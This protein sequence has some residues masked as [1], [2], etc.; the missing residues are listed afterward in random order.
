MN[1]QA[2]LAGLL[3]LAVLL[4]CVRLLA[5]QWRA[6]H[7]SRGWRLALLLI[8]QPLCAVLLY[9]TLLPPGV[10]GRAGTMVVLTAGA[11]ATAAARSAPGDVVIA[12][13]EAAA[14]AAA[15]P[16]GVERAPDLATAL[17]RHPGSRRLHVVG[18]GL[19]ARDRDAVRGRSLHFDASP[20]PAGLVRLEVPERIAPGAAFTIGGAVNGIARGTVELLD[21]AGQRVDAIALD[22]DGAFML[23][24]TVRAPGL[25]GF[26]LRIRDARRM[27]REEVE[28][29]LWVAADPAPRVLLLAGAANPELK[30]L[31][32]WIADAGM[33]AHALI[34]VG[35]G[36]QLGDAPLPLNAATFE[37]FDLLVLDERAWAALGE[38]QRVALIDAVRDGLGVLLRVTGPLSEASRRQLRGLG[39]IVSAGNDSA[40]ARL[41]ERA[42]DDDSLRARRG[43]GS[44]EAP[45]DADAGDAPVL[46]RRVLRIEAGDAASGLRDGA[47]AS[48]AEWRAEGRG[49]IG[50]WTLTDSYR[51]V[52]EGHGD[53]HGELWSDAFATLAR[54]QARQ[55][56]RIDRAARVQQRMR[57]CGISAGARVISADGTTTTLLPDPATGTPACAAYWPAEAGWHLLVQG[58]SSWPF[59]VRAGGEAPALRA[60]E[61]RE[62]TLRLAGERETATSA[63]GD[64]PGDRRGAS[65]PWFLAWLLASA[66]L[67]WFER[68]RLGRAAAAAAV[69]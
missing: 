25:A 10:P 12:L 9:L 31:R 65:W 39:F 48:L 45:I 59:V 63:A 43:A 56:P 13:P 66:A 69:G 20:L 64:T 47:G 8:A 58:A 4:A 62:A 36:L 23:G 53:R 18:A 14:P 50:L 37:R 35:A 33:P 19:E 60:A 3:A 54:A 27:P 52:L 44:R 40:E 1:A 15:G 42:R 11:P 49:R 61:L 22:P 51:W 29:P 26:R 68:S 17:R 21:P 28:V 38:G 2:G 55:A 24:G 6:A 34:S 41:A 30:Y 57:L 5:W 16:A 7:R 46:N 32:R 67:W